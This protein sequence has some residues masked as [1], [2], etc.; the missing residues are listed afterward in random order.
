MARTVLH[1]APPP[2]HGPADSRTAHLLAA[3]AEGQKAENKGSNLTTTVCL[4]QHQWRI[5]GLPG[6]LIDETR[7][8]NPPDEAH[9]AAPMRSDGTGMGAAEQRKCFSAS[10]TG[11]LCI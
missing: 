9:C 5:R 7:V 1:L 8:I 4:H 10:R 2:D 11:Y 3:L 6:R